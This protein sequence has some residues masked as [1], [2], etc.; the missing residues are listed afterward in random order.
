MQTEKAQENSGNA[1]LCAYTIPGDTRM[2]SPLH[3]I[4][5]AT[6]AHTRREALVNAD[7]DRSVRSARSCTTDPQPR[8][9]RRQ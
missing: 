7:A 8:V 3:A 5:Y 6:I 2:M 4:L 9:L 1:V